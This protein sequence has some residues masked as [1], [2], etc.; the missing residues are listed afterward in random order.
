MKGYVN[1]EGKPLK[2]LTKKEKITKNREE[3]SL[4]LT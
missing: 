3:S 2:E 1:R 4:R